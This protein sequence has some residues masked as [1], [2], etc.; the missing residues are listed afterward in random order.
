MNGFQ[1]HKGMIRT[2]AP[3]GQSVAWK[4]F[5]FHK[6]TIRTI[7]LIGDM[8]RSLTFQFHKGTIRTQRERESARYISE[9]SIP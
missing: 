2:R 8:I 1:F 7:R 6:G 5:Q 3:S 4:E 9:I